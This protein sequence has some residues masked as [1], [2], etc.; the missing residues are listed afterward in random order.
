[1]LNLCSDVAQG[2]IVIVTDDST[3]KY[4]Y[5]FGDERVWPLRALAEVT[6]AALVLA[7]VA[8]VL[9]LLRECSVAAFV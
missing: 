5:I 2:N 6:T 1:M 7:R 9:V 3:C 8:T 4:Y